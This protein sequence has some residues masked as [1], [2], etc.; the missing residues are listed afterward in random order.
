M[1]S[2][3]KTLLQDAEEIE[4]CSRGIGGLYLGIH[5]TLCLMGKWT[6]RL[7]SA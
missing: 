7:A 6:E 1:L 3:M 5:L 2:T 4:I